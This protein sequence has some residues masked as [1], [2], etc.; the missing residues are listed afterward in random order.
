MAWDHP[1]TSEI[2]RPGTFLLVGRMLES[3]KLAGK[4]WVLCLLCKA[5]FSWEV[6]IFSW[7]VLIFSWQRAD[8]FLRKCWIFPED[9]KIIPG[10]PHDFFLRI[11]RCLKSFLENPDPKILRETF[12]QGPQNSDD[13]RRTRVLM[14]K[15]SFGASK[16]MFSSFKI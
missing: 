10:D 7:E 12:K 4:L 14:L 3:R 5:N 1:R 2:Q 16:I 11:R 15:I 6:Q 13:Y 9:C 8:F